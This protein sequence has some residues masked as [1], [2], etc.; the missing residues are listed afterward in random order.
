MQP[1]HVCIYMMYRCSCITSTCRHALTFAYVTC[2]Q[3]FHCNVQCMYFCNIGTWAWPDDSQCCGQVKPFEAV[4]PA[5]PAHGLL[6]PDD[7]LHLVACSGS[8][9]KPAY[10]PCHTLPQI[11]ALPMWQCKFVRSGTVWGITLFSSKHRER[12]LARTDGS[13]ILSQY[14]VAERQL[15]TI[16]K[17]L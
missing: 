3:R 16:G 15:L 17:A 8:G 6:L 12:V 1:L 10:L 2:T 13:A 4:K 7:V 11:S 5:S 14:S 9:L